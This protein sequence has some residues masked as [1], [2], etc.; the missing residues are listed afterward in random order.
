MANERLGI[1]EERQRDRALWGDYEYRAAPLATAKET[2]ITIDVASGERVIEQFVSEKIDA[3]LKSPTMRKFVEDE[4]EREIMKAIA[5]SEEMTRWRLRQ[6]ERVHN[7]VRLDIDHILQIVREVTGITHAELR[8]PRRSRKLAWPRHLA[9][10][11]LCKLRPDLSLPQIGHLMGGRDHTTIMH[12]RHHVDDD[13]D[14][15]PFKEWLA[16]SRIAAL[17][18]AK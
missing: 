4:L 9:C 5:K 12:A 16:D 11:L 15:A 3:I 6:L 1:V 10:W 8:S 17:L 2:R 13:C 7:G 18:E 14:K